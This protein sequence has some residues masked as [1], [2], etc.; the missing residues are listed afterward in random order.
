MKIRTFSDT[1]STAFRDG[2]QYL[3]S[4]WKDINYNYKNCNFKTLMPWNR[5]TACNR[6]FPQ[7]AELRKHAKV[8]SVNYVDKFKCAVCDKSFP[9][10]WYFQTH[11]TGQDSIKFYIRF[12][13]GAGPHW[14]L[15]IQVKF[16]NISWKYRLILLIKILQSYIMY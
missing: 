15:P 9:R 13:S 12:Y 10:N 1:L 2:F 14:R 8:H 16:I 3:K 5:C 4:C 7:Q 6:S 11:I